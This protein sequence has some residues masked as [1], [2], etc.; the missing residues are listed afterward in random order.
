MSP[1]VL[2]RVAVLPPALWCP[3]G[4]AL[5]GRRRQDPDRPEQRR[6]Y[7]DCTSRSWVAGHR[8]GSAAG[9]VVGWHVDPAPH[10]GERID[11]P[12]HLAHAA[13]QGAKQVWDGLLGANVV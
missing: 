13:P 9:T 5:A 11:A 12:G 6:R 3:G 7:A 4:L 8:R 1:H 10:T 2:G